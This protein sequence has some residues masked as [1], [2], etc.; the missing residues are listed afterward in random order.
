M[1]TRCH[2]QGPSRSAHGCLGKAVPS[3]QRTLREDGK[4]RRDSGT[5]FLSTAISFSMLLSL[6]FSAFLGMHFTAKSFPVAFSSAKTTSEK[7][8]LWIERETKKG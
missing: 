2:L 5:Y 4:E 7:A 1:S 6:P 3:L 8:P